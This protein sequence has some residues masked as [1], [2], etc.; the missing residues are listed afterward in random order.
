MYKPFTYVLVTYFPTYL[1]LY[2]YIY[3]RHISYRIGPKVKSNINLVKVHPK[4]C[5]NKH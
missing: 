3:M 5:N 2:I 1:P 4:H